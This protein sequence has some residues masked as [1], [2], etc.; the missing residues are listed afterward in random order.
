MNIKRRITLLIIFFSS[1]I[2]LS[3]SNHISQF[4]LHTGNIYVYKQT[5]CCPFVDY[6]YVRCKILRDTLL[7][8]KRYFLFDK[9]L[10]TN[11]SNVLIRFDTLTGNVFVF[12]NNSYC[13]YVNE[14]LIDSLRSDFHNAYQSCLN[15]QYFTFCE[16]TASATIFQ[17][18]WSSRQ[19]RWQYQV[20]SYSQY[21]FTRYADVIG[22]IYYLKGSSTYINSTYYKF[23]LQGCVINGILYGD[24]TIYPLAIHQ[25]SNEIPLKNHLLQ[26]YPNPFNPVTNIK[27]DIP[28]RMMVKIAIYDML[29]KEIS[30]LA[31]E[32]M[33][34]GSYSVDW[35]ASNYP[36]GV[37]FYK[38][39]AGDYSESRKMV[40]LK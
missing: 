34:A 24:T 10:Y 11:D 36:S 16:D 38:I 15:Y 29:G 18:L 28:K 1:Q 13:H 39:T 22:I 32:E 27:F 21:R 23:D 31:N 6:P 9:F 25:I 5:K 40:L 17:K 19:F 20:S 3:Q 8:D 14:D 26:N 33:N 2:L 30:I 4:A 37:Y 12:R 35:D 7:N